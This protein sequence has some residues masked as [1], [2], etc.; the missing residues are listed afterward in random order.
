VEPPGVR[1]ARFYCPD[2]RETFS[3]LPD[4]LAS[5]LSST[6]PEVEQVVREAQQVGVPAAAAK[7][8]PDV[9]LQGGQRWVRR[10]LYAVVAMLVA[11]Q[12]LLPDVLAQCTPAELGS[13][14][15]VL[16]TSAVL[17][18]LRGFA[19]PHLPNL[20]KPTGFRQGKAVRK[21]P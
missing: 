11:L 10:R 16:G 6:L 13:Y 15:R 8:R 3:L 21:P 19:E 14:E 7:L 18:A 4:F 12:G 1:I 5:R 17:P 2:A 20:L 9:G